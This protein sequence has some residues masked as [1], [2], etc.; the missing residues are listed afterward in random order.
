MNRKRFITLIYFSILLFSMQRCVYN[1]IS[2]TAIDCSKTDL[3]MVIESVKNSIGCKTINGEIKVR[4]AGGAPPYRFTLNDA[5]AQISSIFPNLNAGNH[6]VTVNDN[7]NCS[8]SIEAVIVFE[9]SSLAI[10]P[11][12]T[13]DD[14]CTTNNGSITAT[15]IGGYPPYSFSINDGAYQTNPVFMGLG[16]GTFTVKVKDSENCSRSLE[17]RV[18][19]EEP[20]LSVAASTIVDNQCTINNGSITV[21]ATGGKPPYKFQLDDMRPASS[22]IFSSV[23]SGVHS[24]LVSDANECQTSLSVQ[25]PRGVTGIGYT[26]SIKPILDTHC[27][28]SGCHGQGNGTKDWTNFDNVRDKA[29][30]I[31]T[32]TGTRN[33]PPSG[34]LTQDQITM[35]ACWVDD[36]APRN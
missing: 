23:G 29:T 21:F 26:E 4:V 34:E 25:V 2:V 16:A 14:L 12:T 27:N 1:D 24:V 18:A 17:V 36:G 32:R 6:T 19:S 15:A 7:N 3:T 35:I 28:F 13:P 5:T 30:A 9:E 22:N 11:T 10:T 8:T 31:K 20:N 33:M